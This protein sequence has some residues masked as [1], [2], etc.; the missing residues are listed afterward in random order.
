MLMRLFSP[1]ELVPFSGHLMFGDNGLFS[2]NQLRQSSD[3]CLNMPSTEEVLY[4]HVDDIFIGLQ[5]C[6]C[7]KSP[8]DYS[9][10]GKV[11]DRIG[12]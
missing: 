3:S 10:V 5:Y 1:E 4:L 8:M 6:F 12:Q 2:V 7:K 11:Y 9:N